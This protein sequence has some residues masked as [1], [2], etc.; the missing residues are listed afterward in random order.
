MRLRKILSAVLVL[1]LISG[2]NAFALEKIERHLYFDT[3]DMP[4]KGGQL[5]ANVDVRINENALLDNNVLSVT[6]QDP[7][8]YF[9]THVGVSRLDLTNFAFNQY[10]IGVRTMA[11]TV[12]AGK[13]INGTVWV[14]GADG[15][16]RINGEKIVKETGSAFED[17]IVYSSFV[18]SDGVTWFATNKDI[19]TFDKEDRWKAYTFSYQHI[20]TSA[21]YAIFRDSR[22]GMWLGADAVY[23]LDPGKRIAQ[24]NWQ[25]YTPADSGLFHVNAI[26]EV[27]GAVWFGTNRGLFKRSLDANIWE[28]VLS[29]SEL[30]ASEITALAVTPDGALWIGT[31]RGLIS[32]AS[33]NVVHYGSNNGLAGD[34]INSL[35]VSGDS[36]W[37]GTTTG[38]SRLKDGKWVTITRDGIVDTELNLT[39]DQQQFFAELERKEALGQKI[40]DRQLQAEFWESRAG[41]F[42][43][44]KR[45]ETWAAEY[46]FD[47]YDRGV[48]TKKD[49]YNP[50]Q[51]VTRE[52]LVKMAVIAAGF[53]I[54][55]ADTKIAPFLDVPESH[56][57]VPYVNVALAQGI[58]DKDKIFGLG[59]QVTRAEAV[60][61]LLRA[62]SV[63][64]TTAENSKFSDVSGADARWIDTAADLDIIKGYEVSVSGFASAS[65]I[66]SLPR[67]MTPGSQ[68]ENVKDLQ[69]ILQ[70][71]GFYPAQR[72]ITGFYDGTTTDAVADYQV[73]RGILPKFTR[74]QFTEG[75]GAAGTDTRLALLKEKVPT[76]KTAGVQRT[77]DP[78][79]KLTRAQMAKIIYLLVQLHSGGADSSDDSSDDSSAETSQ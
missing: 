3:K 1:V 74:G 33:G 35:A 72:D 39:E 11:Q 69:R 36:L 20:P 71:L 10:R 51:N 41:V 60:Q 25:L 38:A 66:Y 37:I 50:T 79:G 48:F 77:F 32:Y 42:E 2:S 23:Y 68:G 17:L 65:D 52:E 14:G 55:D 78:Q 64:L 8:V 12:S 31:R 18:D 21:S 70:A 67:L 6:V 54:N 53:S 30:P 47:L 61:M 27:N 13:S 40:V 34:V 5:N 49:K 57:A 28:H 56:W 59:V 29:S 15:L 19:Q 43:D 75:L 22:G 44:L 76:G 9:G 7:Y 73:E 26:T 16:A 63:R 58:I 24:Q 45:S 62:F 46:V 4:E